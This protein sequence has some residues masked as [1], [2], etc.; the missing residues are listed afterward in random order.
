LPEKFSGQELS[1][2]CLYNRDQIFASQ[3]HTNN[4]NSFEKDIK[5]L[6]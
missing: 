3:E 6:A 2:L 1:I 5:T 4:V